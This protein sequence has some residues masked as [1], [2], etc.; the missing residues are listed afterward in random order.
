MLTALWFYFYLLSYHLKSVLRR[1][2]IFLK[3]LYH[4]CLRSSKSLIYLTIFIFNKVTASLDYFIA[5]LTV[6]DLSKLPLFLDIEKEFFIKSY[7]LQSY[8]DSKK[9]V[10][11][12]GWGI[13][14]G[15]RGKIGKAQRILW[16]YSVGYL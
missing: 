10:V 1:H 9:L 8:G 7:F 13:G 6:F 3:N 4:R 16:K 2:F 14:R 12:R 11:A 15:M 5:L